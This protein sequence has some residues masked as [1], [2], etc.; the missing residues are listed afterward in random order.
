MDAARHVSV[1]DVARILGCGEPV[2]RG[3]ELVVCCPLHEDT[4]PSCRIDVEDGVWYCDP[5]AE[6]GDAIAL[7]MRARRIEFA[8]AV[9]ELV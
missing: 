5:C 7:Y 3:K 2:R 8:E 9:R 6:G 4:D 1:L